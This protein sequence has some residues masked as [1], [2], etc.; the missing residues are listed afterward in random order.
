MKKKATIAVTALLLVLCFAIGGTLAWLVDKTE[1]VKNTFTSGDVA[2]TLTETWNT[3]GDDADTKPDYWSAQMIPGEEYKKDPK[4]TVDKEKTNVDCYLFVKFE[5][6]EDAKKYLTYTSTLNKDNGWTRG[7]GTDIP[8]NVW[9]RN[10][11]KTDT[12]KSWNLLAGDKI[13][14]NADTVTKETMSTAAAQTLTYTAYAVQMDNLT[15]AQAWSK[16]A[17]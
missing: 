9:Y 8:S 11:Y 6:T 4:V 13:I 10:V 1:P 7:N 2:I 12:T 3:D 15:E 5:E 17:N 14:V 16:V